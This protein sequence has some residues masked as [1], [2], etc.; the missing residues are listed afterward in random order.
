VIEEMR[1]D[2][3]RRVEKSWRFGALTMNLK[4]WVGTRGAVRKSERRRQ[5]KRVGRLLLLLLIFGSDVFGW[6]SA[7]RD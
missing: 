1:R 3:M 4:F 2:E 7:E 5:K 6:D